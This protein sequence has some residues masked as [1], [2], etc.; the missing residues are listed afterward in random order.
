ME[1]SVATR[2]STHPSHDHSILDAQIPG[3]LL[4]ATR[5]RPQGTARRRLDFQDWEAS[6]AA[7]TYAT[8]MAKE[9]EKIKAT[10]NGQIDMINELRV[11]SRRVADS[12]VGK[13]IGAAKRERYD[14]KEVRLLRWHLKQLKAAVRETEMGRTE[15]TRAGRRAR[16]LIA[17]ETKADRLKR[18]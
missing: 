18:G 14:N 17:Q 7:V 3:E 5:V 2:E 12:L 1:Y 11:T 9:T 16:H 10:G 13:T 4:K 8:Q 15:M 6:G